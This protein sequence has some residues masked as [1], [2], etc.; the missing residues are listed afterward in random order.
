MSFVDP[1]KPTGDRFLGVAICEG[2]DIG[3]AAANAWKHE[4]NPGGEIAA[5]PCSIEHI[6]AMGLG[7]EDINH[8]FSEAELDL[9]GLGR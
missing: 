3:E 8:L 6:R 7:D 2:R 4:C 5:L 1:D 9:R